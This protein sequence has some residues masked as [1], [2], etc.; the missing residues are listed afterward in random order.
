MNKRDYQLDPAPATIPGYSFKVDKSG[1]AEAYMITYEL[2]LARLRTD[3]PVSDNDNFTI[4]G[5]SIDSQTTK[6]ASIGKLVTIQSTII[7][8]TSDT[9]LE[10]NTGL[11]SSGT[12]GQSL[13]A[14]VLIAAEPH[15]CKCIVTNSGPLVLAVTR[16]DGGNF[17]SGGQLTLYINGTLI[18]T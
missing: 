2:L 11:F 5:A 12:T 4:T 15:A 8:E 17:P 9:S 18:T 10:V 6:T 14:I 3:F 1:N 7:F 13:N 16:I